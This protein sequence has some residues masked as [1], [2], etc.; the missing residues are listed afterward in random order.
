L[1]KKFRPVENNQI[2]RQTMKRICAVLL[3]AIVILLLWFKLS[4]SKLTGPSSRVLPATN[5][6][7]AEVKTNQPSTQSLQ[8]AQPVPIPVSPPETN[9]VPPDAFNPILATNLD[10]WKAAIKGLK[11]S[12]IF[13]Q[14]S[15]ILDL[16]QTNRRT[17]LPVV[18]IKGS[19]IVPYTAASIDINA[20]KPGGDL[21]EVQ[22]QTPNMD[23]DETKTLGLQLCNM[24]EVDPKDFLTWCDKVGNHWL[25]APLYATNHY[26]GFGINRT[27][28]NEKPWFINFIIAHP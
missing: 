1:R 9:M 15:E 18:L 27:Y 6:S 7:T 13:Y 11:Y 25:D 22:M 20:K 8:D 14:N 2:E 16:E 19:Q 3:L 12:D 26:Y 10:Q 23:I 21:I 5:A 24:L 4:G 28:D 17:G